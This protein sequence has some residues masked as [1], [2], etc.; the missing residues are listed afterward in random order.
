MLLG[1]FKD[2]RYNYLE[3]FP[4]KILQPEDADYHKYKCRTNYFSSISSSIGRLES[5]LAKS[6]RQLSENT[7]TKCHKFLNFCETL[8]GREEKYT[9]EEINIA[10]EILDILIKEL[11]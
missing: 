2:L 1:R 8:R 5:E 7:K 10:N 3:D 6:N 11:S 9:I 4:E